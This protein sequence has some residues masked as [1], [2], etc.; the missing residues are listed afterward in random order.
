V[1]IDPSAF[2]PEGD[3]HQDRERWEITD[4]S[5]ADWALRKL[6][7]ARRQ[8]IENQD[9]YAA[10]VG[11]LDSWLEEACRSPERDVEYFES[12]L[13][14]WHEEQLQADPEDAEAWKREKKK[15][16]KLP[17]GELSVAKNP[18]SV[19]IDEE[20]FVPW[21]LENQPEWVKVER[22]VTRKPIANAVKEAGGIDLETGE[23][24]PGVLVHPGALRWKAV[25]DE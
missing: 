12:V 14:N 17:A 13:R 24:A 16:I 10:E 7:Q 23:V 3:E 21:A 25:T 20:K 2:E 1:V 8:I 11:R 22:K 18:P 4:A 6:A 5:A 15:T 19:E 9:L